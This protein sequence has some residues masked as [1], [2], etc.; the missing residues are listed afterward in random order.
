MLDYTFTLHIF[1][2]GKR[3]AIFIHSN[4]RDLSTNHQQENRLFS[5][6]LANENAGFGFR[7][8]IQQLRMRSLVFL[9]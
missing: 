6:F 9:V 7:L 3:V 8:D 5:N 2:I 1:K 4:S